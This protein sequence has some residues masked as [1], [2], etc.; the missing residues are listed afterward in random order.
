MLLLSEFS[1][2][3]KVSNNRLTQKQLASLL[4]DAQEKV[5]IGSMYVHYKNQLNYLVV[6]L[7]IQESDMSV[8]VVYKA[9]YGDGLRFTRPLEAWLENIKW[10]GKIVP[11]FKKI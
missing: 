4:V 5:E 3:N 10:Q 8:V 1:V 6:D 7:A 2:G 11:R 9:D